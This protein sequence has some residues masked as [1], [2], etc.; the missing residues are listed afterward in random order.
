MGVFFIIRRPDVAGRDAVE[1][2]VDWLR[3]EVRRDAELAPAA[4]ARAEADDVRRRANHAT[5][6][7]DEALDQT[8]IWLAR[9]S[10]GEA[11]RRTICVDIFYNADRLQNR[12]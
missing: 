12:K 4:G 7:K 2:F 8:A 11:R 10:V 5:L 1:A 3:S 6:Q 9:V